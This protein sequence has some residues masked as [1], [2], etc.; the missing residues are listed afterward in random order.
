MTDFIPPHPSVRLL[1]DHAILVGKDTPTLVAADLHLGKSATFR[2]HGL[3]VP[4]GDTARDLARLQTLI[5]EHKAQ[6]IVIAGDLFHADSGQTR[7]VIDAF[8]GF[9]QQIA[10]PFTL[11]LGNHDEKIHS[12]PPDLHATPRLDL[13][14]IRI[15]HKPTDTS[16][17]HFNI[18]GHVHPI[19]RIPD[20]KKTSLRLPCFHLRKTSSPSP[21]SA[22]S[23]AATSSPPKRATAF[24]S[25]TRGKSSKCPTSC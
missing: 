21:P 10:I 14:D 7:E 9:L 20:G 11:V 2:S 23:P 5:S 3:P 25:P 16:D 1:A 15:V 19:V 18:C 6:R 17:S 24:S 22:P 13:G 12:L 8:L 4:E